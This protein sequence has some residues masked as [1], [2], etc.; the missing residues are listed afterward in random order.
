MKVHSRCVLRL[1][2]ARV[3]MEMK[4]QMLERQDLLV[5]KGR[6]WKG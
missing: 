3:W 6:R 4:H 5:G 1:H 2:E